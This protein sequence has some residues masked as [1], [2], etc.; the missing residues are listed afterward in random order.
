MKICSANRSMTQN[1]IEMYFCYFYSRGISSVIAKIWFL[2][3][4]KYKVYRKCRINPSSQMP[5]QIC[6]NWWALVLCISFADTFVFLSIFQYQVNRRKWNYIKNGSSRQLMLLQRI[7]WITVCGVKFWILYLG[8]V[9]RIFLV[10]CHMDVLKNNW[11]LGLESI[12]AMWTPCL[13]SNRK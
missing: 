4:S 11:T 13:W 8:K 10:S 7:S 5:I 1:L 2:N 9:S 6:F 12:Q 3:I